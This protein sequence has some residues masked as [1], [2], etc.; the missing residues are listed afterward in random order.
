LECNGVTVLRRLRLE[1]SMNVDAARGL[2]SGQ[3][4]ACCDLR[5][6]MGK[7]AERRIGKTESRIC[8]EEGIDAATDRPLRSGLGRCKCCWHN[9]VWV[10]AMMAGLTPL[11]V[12]AR[13]VRLMATLKLHLNLLSKRGLDVGTNWDLWS[14]VI[15]CD[16][17]CQL[18]TWAG[19]EALKRSLQKASQSSFNEL[20]LLFAPGWSTDCALR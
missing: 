16:S 2:A 7:L 4:L 10:M 12:R 8:L 6:R 17:L 9:D 18:E 3:S 5:G 20:W 11:S 13:T 15:C 19:S 14:L 1:E